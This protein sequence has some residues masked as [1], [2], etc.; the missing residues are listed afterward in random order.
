MAYKKV[1][2]IGGGFAGLNA[3]KLLGKDEMEVLVIDKTNH[4]VFQPL[5]Y[6]VATAALSAGNIAAPIREILRDQ[7]NTSVIMANI[8][9]IEKEKHQIIACNGEIYPYDYL[10]VAVGARHSYFGNDQWEELAPGLKS[11]NDAM[12]IRERILLAFERAERCESL[13]TATN[14]LRFVIIG[15]GPTGVEMA[16]S[17][18]EIARKTMFKNF[19]KIKPELSEIY[20][21]EG[22]DHVLGSY[23]ERLCDIARRDL[24]KMGVKVITNVFV[25][26]I[27]EHGVTLSDGRH[28]ESI[29]VIWA[30]GNQASPLLK[31][32]DTPL[33][34]QGRAIVNPD[35]SIPGHPE[36]FV[37]GDA[38]HVKDRKDV[39]L[40][41]IA[42]VAIQEGRY[43]AKIIRQGVPV[44]KRKPFKYFDKGTMAT[45]GKAKAIAQMG[46]L[47][48]SGFTAWLA[49]C[50]IH[51]L[52]LISFRNRVVVGIQW[53]FWYLTGRRQERLISRP[54]HEDDHYYGLESMREA[55]ES[56]AFFDGEKL[57]QSPRRPSSSQIGKS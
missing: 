24:E 54:V 20:L 48:I 43:V 55:Q 27:D 35:L 53:L 19:R 56:G 30:A 33:D 46:K 15:G 32:L 7:E 28:I 4:H 39:P 50:F 44:D 21:I 23:P 38:A 11:I 16:G 5:L 34:R 8:E 2:I 22:T 6:Q 12:L 3:A 26:G 42:P 18:A 14:Y 41:G 17:I 49:W 52:Y 10:I 37:V 45:I 57:H 40:P 1:V 25:T 51:I 13:S 36:I 29:N 9:R 47:Q 31:T